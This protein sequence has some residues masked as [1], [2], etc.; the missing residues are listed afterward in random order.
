MK[1]KQPQSMVSESLGPR[2][3][4]ESLNSKHPGLFLC[5][6]TDLCQICV[7]TFGL[8]NVANIS[9]PCSILRLIH[10]QLVVN[11][12]FHLVFCLFICVEPNYVVRFCH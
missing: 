3:S 2:L 1:I 10:I 5:N 11:Y 12:L 4:G 9:E 6:Y 7:L 8:E